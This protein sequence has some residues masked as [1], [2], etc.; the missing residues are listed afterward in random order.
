[1][2]DRSPLEELKILLPSLEGKLL[3]ADIWSIN[4]AIREIEKN[5]GNGRCNQLY[6]YVS[7]LEQVIYFE[8]RY[9]SNPEARE[10]FRKSVELLGKMS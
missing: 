5:N 7:Y 8:P 10:L 6:G 3:R 1:M 2:I 4:E 9:R